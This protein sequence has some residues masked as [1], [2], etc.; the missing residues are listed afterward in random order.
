MPINLNYKVRFLINEN[1]NSK[2]FPWKR[3]IFWPSFYT[4][5]LA[6]FYVFISAL[7]Y[8][9]SVSRH[10]FWTILEFLFLLPSGEHGSFQNP[11][12]LPLQVRTI[13]QL[14][15]PN[16]TASGT[17]EHWNSLQHHWGF[18]WLPFILPW[19]SLAISGDGRGPS[20]LPGSVLQFPGALCPSRVRSAWWAESQ[21]YTQ[22]LTVSPSP[23]HLGAAL[24]GFCRFN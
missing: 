18:P 15:G 24:Q 23:I 22:F 3:Y 19:I 1:S 20:F 6:C 11:T 17:W 14:R 9:F 4:T 2:H 7:S 8:Q 10:M 12:F 13:D 5:R 21:D 16:P